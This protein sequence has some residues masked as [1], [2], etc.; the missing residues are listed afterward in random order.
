MMPDDR[1][2]LEIR[3]ARSPADTRTARLTFRLMR[4]LRKRYPDA[5]VIRCHH[6]P[7][8]PILTAVALDAGGRE[9]GREMRAAR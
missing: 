3:P 8:L 1:E 9:L 7:T 5:A 6:D 2:P 4:R